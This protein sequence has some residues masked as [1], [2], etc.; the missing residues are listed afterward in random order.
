MAEHHAGRSGTADG[1][2]SRP[3][4]PQGFTQKVATLVGH[5]RQQGIAPDSAEGAQVVEQLLDGAGADRRAYVH[6]R[7]AAGIDSQSDRYHELLGVINGQ[8][9]CPSR[10]PDLRWL[11]AAIDSHPA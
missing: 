11:I 7:L 2:S 5:A 9:A 8:Q 1:P 10:A 3:G 6:T 4:M